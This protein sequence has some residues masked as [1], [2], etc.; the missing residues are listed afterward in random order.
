MKIRRFIP[1]LVLVLLSCLILVAAPAVLYASSEYPKDAAQKFEMTLRQGLGI[2]AI[3][4]PLIWLGAGVDAL[5]SRIADKAKRRFASLVVY[6]GAF[7]L[8]I[9]LPT[10]MLLAIYGIFSEQDG[11]QQLPAPPEAPV[12][13]ASGG[14]D[15][16]I[17]ETVDGNYYSCWALDLSTCWQPVDQPESLIM[18]A[19]DVYLEQSSNAPPVNPPGEV[20]SLIGVAYNQ[21]GMKLESHYAVLEDGTVWYLNRETNNYTASFITMLASLLAIPGMIGSGLAFAGA[22]IHAFTKWMLERIPPKEI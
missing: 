18:E 7:V 16:L 6:I 21:S 8:F 11:W 1:L 20:L 17:V 12:A 3:V 19:P 13:V 5:L 9:A 22:G 15:S 10:V 2:A 4:I 14:R